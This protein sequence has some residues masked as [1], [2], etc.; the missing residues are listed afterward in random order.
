MV[1]PCSIA[2]AACWASATSFPVAPD[3]RHSLSSMSRWSGPGPTTRAVGRSTSEDTNANDWSSVD[4]GVEYPGI[5]HD[6]YETGQDQDGKS[7]WFSPR[8]QFGDP[9]RVLGVIRGR[10]FDVR[11]HQDIYIRKQ[12]LESQTPG[13]ETGLVFQCIERPGLVKV[14]SWA[15]MHTTY[16]HQHEGG[17]FRR[18]ATLQSIMQR[19]RDEGAHADA[20]GFSGPTHLLGKLV[21]KGD[22]RSH[23]AI[24]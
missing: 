21:I 13:P 10:V 18:L 22:C 4:G 3:P 23:D 8:R 17:L 24:A 20:A 19:S 14:D 12:H 1:Q 16:G 11:I 9:G 15:G 7:E 6:S 5:G 2:T